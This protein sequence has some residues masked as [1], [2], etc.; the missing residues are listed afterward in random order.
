MA[1]NIIVAYS[2]K[3]SP[4]HFQAVEL[5]KTLAEYKNVA[6][7]LADELEQKDF[8]DRDL[9]IALGGDGTFL[10]ASHFINNGIGLLGINSEPGESEGALTPVHYD[11]IAAISAILAGE[12]SEVFR[13][14]AEVTLNG[15]K[16]AELALNEVYVGAEHQYTSSRYSIEF[17]GNRESQ[18][19]SGVLI[20]TGSGS[21]AWFSSAGGEPFDYDK[22]RLAFKVREPY[23]GKRIF[24][25]KILEGIIGEN[26]SIVFESERHNGGI[27]AI[28]G[29]AAYDFN[30]GDRAEIKLSDNPLRVI[31]PKEK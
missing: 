22:K 14:R 5:L 27:L 3:Q 26:Q 9:A 13:Q 12:Y 18:R 17:C 19:T 2:R 8:A 6:F 16:L 23:T 4:A 25:P 1:K 10:R 20:A 24:K 28:D 30:N 21:N 31:I 11:D 15:A 7:R 29:L